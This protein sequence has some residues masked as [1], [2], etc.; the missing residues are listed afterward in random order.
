MLNK[1]LLD[2]LACPVC[3][4]DL[5][6]IQKDKEEFLKCE[7]CKLL[8]PIKEDIPILLEDEVIKEEN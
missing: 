5:I 1:E 2:I 8:Y 6:L 4:G 3:K 7:N